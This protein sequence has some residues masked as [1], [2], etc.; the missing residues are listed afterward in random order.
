MEDLGYGAKRREKCIYSVKVRVKWLPLVTTTPC[1]NTLSKPTTRTLYPCITHRP[2]WNFSSPGHESCHLL[3][4]SWMLPSCGTAIYKHILPG[5]P[6]AANHQQAI[7][8]HYLRDWDTYLPASLQRY[9]IAPFSSSG[10][11]IRPNNVSFSICLTNFGSFSCNPL[12]ISVIVYP[13]LRL[14]TRMP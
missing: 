9:K 7:S 4:L 1:M 8:D 5:K 11:P 12:I 14:L 13:G 10:M 3:E 6:S 2:E